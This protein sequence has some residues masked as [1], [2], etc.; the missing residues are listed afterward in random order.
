MSVCGGPGNDLV[1][2]ANFDAL[3]RAVMSRNTSQIITRKARA[4]APAFQQR[5]YGGWAMTRLRTGSLPRAMLAQLVHALNFAQKATN[6]SRRPFFT[7]SPSMTRSFLPSILSRARGFSRSSATRGVPRRHR[8][9]RDRRRFGKRRDRPQL[10]AAKARGIKLGS[11]EQAKINRAE[12][13][14]RA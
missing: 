4:F 9:Q 14:A 13:A 12:A 11:P 7:T 1:I 10:A 6:H 5:R 3:Y 8:S 2:D